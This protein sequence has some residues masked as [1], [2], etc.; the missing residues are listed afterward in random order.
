VNRSAP[1]VY[2]TLALTACGGSSSPSS[3]Q[4][5]APGS[6]DVIQI[7]GRERFGWNQPTDSVANYHF[8]VYVD[9]ARTELPTAMCRPSTMPEMF[10]C[11][12]PLPPLT[13]GRHT[14]EVV[15]V[16]VVQGESVEGP[17]AV[18]LVVNVTGSGTASTTDMAMSSPVAPAAPG[19]STPAGDGFGCG[20]AALPSME[21]AKW[22]ETGAI[23]VTDIRS[24]ASRDVTWKSD[25]PW[26]L[27]ALATHP[28]FLENRQ[29]YLVE[30]PASRETLRLS[31]YREVGGV[32]GERAVLLQTAL[33]AR[34]D[35]L[36]MSFGVD[37]NL[38]IGL[39]TTSA[40]PVS[41]QSNSERFLIRVT[42]AGLPAKGN[43]AA[44]LFAPVSAPW[45][46][47]M[48]W[49]PDS[50]IPWMLTRV[51]SDAYSV[52]QLGQPQ[53]VEHRLYPASMPVAMQIVAIDQQLTLFVTGT[54]GDVR[55]LG[56]NETGWWIRDG[57]LLSEKT[58]PVRDALVLGNGEMAAC[59]PVDGSGYG[60]WRVRLP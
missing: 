30:M 31:R 27:A 1:A 17:R 3:P 15:A 33:D 39:L 25:P 13:P 21:F 29:V 43:A 4:S 37:G 49:S 7:T 60:I 52:S 53:A 45:P 24:G 54:H 50:S 46:A 32:L 55:R 57:F 19:S 22:D 58:R 41:K 38:Y 10:D 14:L 36:W 28:K 20:L 18:A 26:T 35:R 42:E 11:E 34:P 6:G 16:V 48:A 9:S 59:G 12:S 56:R 5:P 44:S 2:L 51:S 47:V 8:A 23:R 40:S